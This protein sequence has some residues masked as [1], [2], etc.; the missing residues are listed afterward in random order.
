MNIFTTLLTQPLAN[1]LILFYRILGGNLGL[2]IIVFSLALR[3]AL[4]PLTKPYMDSM[5]NMKKYEKELNKLKQRHKGDKAKLMQAQSDFYKEKGINPSAG[6]LPY[7]LQI[8]ILI[9]FFR[10]F[11]GVLG[12]DGDL[13]MKFNELLYPPLQFAADQH[14]ATNFLYLDLKNPD[15]FNLPSLQ[16]PLPGPLLILAAAVQFLSAKMSQPYIEEEKKLAKKTE[17]KSDDF[18]VAMQSS[19]IYTFP[20]ITIVAGMRFPSGLAIYWAM[21]SIY[22]VYQQYNSGGW[23]GATPFIKRLRMIKLSNSNGERKDN[24]E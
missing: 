20:L 12:N 10:M 9:A 1:G 11:I 6:C 7:L 21:F 8:V 16:F 17:G 18:A 23:G 24:K 19:M 4:S 14:I 2:A 22:Q 5:K 15:V 3:A 13:A